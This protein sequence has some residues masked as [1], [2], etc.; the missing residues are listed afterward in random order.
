MLNPHLRAC[1]ISTGEEVLRGELV[2]TNSVHLAQRLGEVGF[3][4]QL[5]LTTGDRRDD[6]RWAVK[7]GLERGE[8]V[9]LSG[10]LGPTTD[11][12]TTEV[13]AEHA[14]VPLYFHA[15][16]WQHIEERFREFGIPVTD[17]NRKQ[18]LFPEGARVLPNPNGTAPGFV[19]PFVT[20][21]VIKEVVAFPGPPREMQPML[22]K[23]LATLDAVHLPSHSFARLFGIG[24]SSLG[25]IIEGWAKDHDIEVGY[26]ALFPEVELKLYD[27]ADDTLFS[28]QKFLLEHLSEYLVDFSNL[29]IPDLFAQ[30]LLEAGQTFAVAESCTGGLIA[31]IV[32]DASGSSA[33]FRGGIIAY[34]NDLKERF[35]H[36][37]AEV[38]ATE[39]AVS[40]AVARQ[41][42]EEVRRQFGADL[43]LSVTGIAGPT[44][45]SDAKPVG[46]VWLAKASATGCETREFHFVRGRDRIRICSAYEGM[47]WMMRD[48]LKERWQS[49]LL[50]SLSGQ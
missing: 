1:I 18:V 32:T 42:A 20:D 21:G 3:A 35:L 11:D 38:L 37:P 30:F 34:H 41:M 33:Y 36:V 48:W 8:Y 2:D 29:S 39:G 40:A 13:I 49:A 5:M 46:T 10:G 25:E 31:K 28:F 6:L 17:N 24:E 7:T 15:P 44:G 45:G 22:E 9:F 14:G 47:R 16:S 23:Y 27:V 12:L 19:M 50:D 4:V 43:A 26:R